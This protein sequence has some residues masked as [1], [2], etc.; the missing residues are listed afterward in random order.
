MVIRRQAARSR[1]PGRQGR[2]GGGCARDVR[3]HADVD[4]TRARACGDAKSV[5][6]HLGYRAWLIDPDA[7][8]GNRSEQADRVEI[9]MIRLEPHSPRDLARDRDDGVTVGLSRG[10]A[11]DRVDQARPRR[12]HHDSRPAGAAPVSL[13]HERPGGLMPHGDEPRPAVC[14]RVQDRRDGAP[15]DTE[16]KRHLLGKKT[17]DQ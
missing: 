15:R 4:G 10:N 6:Q 9:L 14:E 13:G 12:R 2:T 8:L 5:R 3:R 7:P 11:A 1:H 16:D 17:S